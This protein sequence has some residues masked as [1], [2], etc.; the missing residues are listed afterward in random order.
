MQAQFYAELNL[1]LIISSLFI[2]GLQLAFCL[3]TDAQN[4]L[5]S[6]KVVDEEKKEALIGVTVLAENNT[7]TYTDLNGN[8]KLSLKAGPHQLK[9]SYIG[10]NDTSI[11]ILIYEETVVPAIILKQ[12]GSTLNEIV[13]GANRYSRPLAEQTVSMNILHSQEL[14]NKNLQSAAEALDQVPGITV[15]DG[16]AGIRGGSGYAFGAG[17]RVMIV[18]DDQPLLTADRNDV[19]WNFIPMENIDQMEI[20]KGASSVQYG[21]AALNGVVNIHTS[22]PSDTQETKF[23]LFITR[24]DGSIPVNRLTDSAKTPYAL[25]GY[26]LH[27]RK[28]GKSDFVYDA[29]AH[30]SQSWLQ[31]DFDKR[32]RGHFKYRYRINDRMQFGV[33][34]TGLFQN[35]SQ[36]LF[37]SNDSTGAYQPLQG[38]TTLVVL[39][40]VYTTVDPYLTFFTKGGAKNSLHL[41][42]Y[43]TNQISTGIWQPV[44][45]LYSGDYFYQKQ[46]SSWIL[47]SGISG[48]IYFFKDDGLGGLHIGN[49]GAA[50]FQLEKNWKHFRIEGGARY[51]LFRIDTIT[52]Q[53][54]PVGRLGIQYSLPKKLFL[55]SSFGQGFR[56]PSPAERF[57][58]Y[59]IGDI[60]VYP[61]PTLLPEE[62]WSA[63]LGLRKQIEKKN[64]NGFVDGAFYMMGYKNMMEFTFGQWGKQTD[65]L[66]G[67]GFKSL[68][69]NEARI[70]GLE[71]ETGGKTI[72]NK[73]K[74]NFNA[75]YTYSYPVDLQADSALRNPSN[76]IAGFVKGFTNPDSLFKVGLLR[77]RN[78]HILK[79]N[80]DF[81][82]KKFSFGGTGR[83]YSRMDNIDFYFNLFIPGIKNYRETHLQGDWVFDLRFAYQTTYG[84]IALLCNNLLNADYAIRIGKPDAPRNFTLQYS[85]NF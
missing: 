23:N 62:G 40:E 4:I 47:S 64:F 39:K 54:K 61:N 1:K 85:F 26:F 74:W 21:S 49:F 76:F 16:Q 31:G 33:N 77:Y 32:V 70:A 71:L 17:S 50:F 58:T 35:T 68:N 28:I 55:R 7:G 79:F 46:F 20:V 51:E 15:I 24:Y 8:W 72:V 43:H 67:L 34:T 56:F 30:E 84:K 18:L 5:V 48:N 11:A 14:Q 41:R 80:S 73:V 10:W 45:N 6:G 9:F 44:T 29:Y 81:E 57:V 78:R 2:L 65:P 66:I 52:D 83:F 3:K 82:W 53:S 12:K 59:Y 25:G 19:K 42:Y 27:K 37:W 36:F 13:V 69:V 75:G 22:F 60:H 38:T 63:E